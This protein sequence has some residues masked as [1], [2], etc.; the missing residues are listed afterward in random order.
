M[1]GHPMCSGSEQVEKTG[2]SREA[3][4]RFASGD[5]SWRFGPLREGG[6]SP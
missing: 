1:T 2:V 6:A 5:T 3:G 4:A